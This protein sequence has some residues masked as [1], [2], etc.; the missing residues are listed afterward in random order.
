MNILIN[1]S[2]LKSGGGLQV[3]DSICCDL[4]RFHEH[5]FIVVL[6]SFMKPTKER[7]KSVENVVVHEYNVRNNLCTLAFGR[8]S[9]LDDLV[10]SEHIDAAL[11]IFGPSRWSPKCPHLQ[12]F[13]RAHL[14][15]ADSPYFAKMVKFD[16][17]KSQIQNK[18][19][20]HF[21]KRSARYFWTEN[22][23]ISEKLERLFSGSRVFTVTNYYNQIYDCPKA[24]QE[25]RLPAFEGVT[26]LTVTAAYPHKNLPISIEIAELLK[27]E[28]PDFKFRFVFTIDKKQFPQVP[29][30]LNQHF[31][32]TGSVDITECPSLYMQADIM[33]QPTLL[34]CFTATYPE[35]MK[36]KVPI[37]T[38]DIEFAKGLCGSAAVY[39][40]PLSA[41]DAAFQI[42]EVATNP[43]LRRHLVE[44]GARQLSSYDSYSARSEKLIHL[45]EEI[46]QKP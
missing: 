26:L 22:P 39:Y 13:A 25:K 29:K 28:H 12:G 45:I 10:K 44:T 27:H 18:V 37:V 34:E 8:D 23:Y 11:T 14:V 40:S 2:N 38:T 7:L 1:A 46:G 4:H 20:G 5:R 16:L 19:L 33:F 9:F 15:L 6:S 36:M 3:A 21:F 43:D 32:F 30:H 35:A 31:H 17:W 41:K 42:Y 24:W